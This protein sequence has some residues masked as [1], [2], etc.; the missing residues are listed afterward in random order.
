MKKKEIIGYVQ[1]AVMVLLFVL[2][3]SLC[4]LYI[5]FA[6]TFDDGSLPSFPE[7]EIM[8]LSKNPEN[9]E[10]GAKQLISPYFIGVSGK[11][12]KYAQ[13]F[14]AEHSEE[15]WENFTEILEN[16][17]LGASEKV[18]LSSAEAK[19]AYLE[20]LY[21]SGEDYFYVKFAREIEYSVLC[22]FLSD[23]YKAMPENPGFKISDMFLFKDKS[24]ESYIT[25]VSSDGE[26]LK[27][28][29]SKKILFNKE[30][31]LTYN[32]K[33]T[34]NFEFIKIENNIK[35]GKNGYFPAYRHPLTAPSII[36]LE[37][38]YAFD[39]SENS[40]DAMDFIGIFGMNSDNVKT[41][42]TADY[43]IVFVEDMVRLSISDDGIVEFI[44]GEE[45]T[46]IS[47][48]YDGTVADEYGFIQLARTASQIAGKINEKLSEC[49][50]KLTFSDV[51]YREGICEF[52]FDY[53]VD[54][55]P[56]KSNDD[57]G[58]LLQFKGD[59]LTYA[60]A[61]IKPYIYSSEYQTEM[62]QKTAYAMLKNRIGGNAVYFG[63]E[64][65][66][67]V[68]D[69]GNNIGTVNWTVKTETEAAK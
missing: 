8:L 28:F 19:N 59:S 49:A 68:D 53:T 9:A 3:L 21:N 65:S 57:F 35:N 41:Y 32:S 18:L 26:V 2:M 64:Y 69:E 23:T 24:D 39:F 6:E 25:A 38:A 61:H 37:F 52:Y 10:D 29:P 17:Y 15:I 46:H 56:V 63:A 5:R 44:P 12:F 34:R 47:K 31:F 54:A 55:L 30:L 20:K 13:T 14:G 11:D 42:R 48:L 45:G 27:I 7:S 40:K 60:K 43:N 62:S 50:A 22:S 58:I 67:S 36:P 51:V 4:G 33:E 1:T 16:S 66:L